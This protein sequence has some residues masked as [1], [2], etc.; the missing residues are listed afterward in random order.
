MVNGLVNR[1]LFRP[2][3]CEDGYDLPT[4]I[5]K[6]NTSRGNTISAIYLRRS[7]K[8]A[9]TLLY[10]HENGEDLNTSY[11]YLRKLSSCLNVNVMAYDY[12]GYGESTGVPSELN[13]Y[14]DIT[15]VYEYL[16]KEKK[17][18]PEHIILYGRSLGS[19]P[20]CYLAEEA[21]CNGHHLAG[22]VLHAAFASIYRIVMPDPGFT[23]IGDMFPNIDRIKCVK[24]PVFI[25]HGEADEIIPFKHAKELLAATPN[26]SK[27]MF[28][29]RKQMSHNVLEG[30]IEADLMEAINDFMDY[31]VLARRL[32]MKPAVA[33]LHR[34]K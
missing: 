16:T 2:P 31:H 4:P 28:F 6:L 26:R 14:A 17:I 30:T 10:S 12:S 3:H 18:P 11:R 27:T 13:C 29:T 32:W 22:L 1:V 23:V 25:A 19:G 34:L 9:L 33:K 7:A 21:A 15:A 8:T 20:S 5:I 24:C